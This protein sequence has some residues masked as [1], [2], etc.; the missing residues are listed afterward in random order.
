MQNAPFISTDVIN[1]VPQSPYF[2]VVKFDV[3]NVDRNASTL[4]K[5]EFRIYR[6]QNTHAR[7]TEQRVEI[8]QVN[9]FSNMCA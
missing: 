7:A 4:V 6:V 1:T 5:A 8:Y 2:R 3:T 9:S